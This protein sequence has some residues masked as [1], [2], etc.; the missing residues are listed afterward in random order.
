M[1]FQIRTAERTVCALWWLIAGML[2]SIAN[3]TLIPRG[4]GMI[5]DDVMHVTWLPD[6]NSAATIRFRAG[7]FLIWS[8]ASDWPQN[9]VTV[10]VG[11]QLSS[12]DCDHQWLV[13]FPV[14]PSVIQLQATKI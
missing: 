11:V 1:L 14:A 6:A 4:Y 9:N 12:D 13:V 5:H 3:V 10:A 7:G 2:T 8:D